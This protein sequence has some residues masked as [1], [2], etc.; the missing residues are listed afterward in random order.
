MKTK[1][2][3]NVPNKIYLQI[4]DEVDDTYDFNDLSEVTH[5]TTRVFDSDIVYY[6]RKCKRKK[7][8]VQKRKRN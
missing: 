7:V 1:P 3:K 5:S 6:R 2:P 4:G 8:S